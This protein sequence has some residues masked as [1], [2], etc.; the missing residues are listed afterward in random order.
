MITALRK[1]VVIA[2]CAP[3]QAIEQRGLSG[4]EKAGQH[5]KRNGR[6]HWRAMARRHC[7]SV[8]GVI[9]SGV[10]GAGLALAPAV[11]ASALPLSAEGL[12]AYGLATLASAAGLECTAA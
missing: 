2:R 10:F 8:L 3:E 9:C 7:V 5:R 4:A 6:R 1:I 12:P 11:A